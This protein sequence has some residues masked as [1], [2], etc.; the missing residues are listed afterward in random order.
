[1]N[2]ST[3]GSANQYSVSY[4]DRRIYAFNPN[5]IQITGTAIQQE[6][7]VTTPTMSLRRYTGP[8]MK[9]KFPIQA[10]LQSFFVGVE[11]GDVNAPIGNTYLNNASKATV[12]S[13]ITVQIGAD[14]K[15]LPFDVSWGGLSRGEV[16]KDVETI[17]Q[18]GNLPLT[19]T[20]TD[21]SLFYVY[22][23]TMGDT[24]P[25]VLPFQL[26]YNLPVSGFGFGKEIYL[27]NFPSYASFKDFSMQIKVGETVIKTYNV[28]KSDYVDGI[29]LRWID[30]HGAYK[31]YMFN[32]GKTSRQTKDGV[33]FNLYID[34]IEPSSG[35]L[36]KG[37]SQL[38]NI[39]S[40]PIDVCG[41]TADVDLQ[42]HL[43]DLPNAIKV[44][45]YMNGSWFEV[46]KIMKPIEIDR[47]QQNSLIELTVISPKLF[48]QQL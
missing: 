21:G 28:I 36:I 26:A 4:P 24:L 27:N 9:V 34:N 41:C 6:V 31:Y 30:S 37:D 25:G 2:T 40:N 3:F 43:I 44:W 12:S 29:Y 10:I 15:V 35:G 17:Y 46:Q 22:S 13:S 45:K 16:L 14:S 20:Q 23:K 1:M 33:S 39:S 42:N 38:K 5:I 47:L 18:F 48:T 32:M 19:V 11:F 8:D 7:I